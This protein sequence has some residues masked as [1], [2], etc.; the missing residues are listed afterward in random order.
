MEPRSDEVTIDIAAP[1]ERVWEIVAD[2]TGMGQR[3]PVCQSCEWLHGA[4]GPAVGV[5]FLGRNRYLGVRWTRECEIRVW[6]PPREFAFQTVN[7]GNDETLWTYRVEPVADGT[8]VT[9]SY[10]VTDGPWYVKALYS[11]PGTL[12]KARADQV[13]GMRRTLENIKRTAEARTD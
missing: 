5:R 13:D 4:A 7:R 10:R 3:S 8:R 12:Q 11:I 6:D 9:E 1:P 2:I